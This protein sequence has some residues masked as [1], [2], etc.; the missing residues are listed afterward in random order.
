MIANRERNQEKRKVK[1]TD[2]VVEKE[3]KNGIRVYILR[4]VCDNTKNRGKRNVGFEGSI[5]QGRRPD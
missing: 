1:R 4:D 3:K 5:Y 2:S